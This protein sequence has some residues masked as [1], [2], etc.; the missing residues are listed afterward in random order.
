MKRMVAAAADSQ[1]QQQQQT[2]KL[3]LDVLYEEFGEQ[4]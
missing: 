4:Q 1:A 3:R 2:A